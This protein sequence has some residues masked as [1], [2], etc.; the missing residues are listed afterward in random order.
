MR[1]ISFI[2]FS[3]KCFSGWLAHI[4]ADF[5]PDTQMRD[6]LIGITGFCSYPLLAIL[7]KK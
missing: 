2:L 4:V 5:L 6:S 1:K 3:C 7:E